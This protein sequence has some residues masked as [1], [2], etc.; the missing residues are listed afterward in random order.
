MAWGM[1]GF[2]Q[3]APGGGCFGAQHVRTSLNKF[4]FD[5]IERDHARLSRGVLR[6]PPFL[7]ANVLGLQ[8]P[9]G[10]HGEGMKW[11]A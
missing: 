2:S 11:D 10:M 5:V 8:T 6:K 3:A 9:D 1:G 7:V 4:D